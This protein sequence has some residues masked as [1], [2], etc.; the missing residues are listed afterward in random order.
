[1]EPDTGRTRPASTPP[2]AGPAQSPLSEAMGHTPGHGGEPGDTSAGSRG[3]RDARFL[4][5]VP[6][7][8]PGAEVRGADRR[9]VAGACCAAVQP[10]AA[11]PG[12]AHGRGRAAVVPHGARAA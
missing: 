3:A 11:R 12:P 10:V 7:W 4:A 1:M 9:A 6:A 2:S 5:R 8:H